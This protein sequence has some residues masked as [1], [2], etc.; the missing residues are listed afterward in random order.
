MTLTFEE[1]APHRATPAIDEPKEISAILGPTNTGKTHY[2]IERMLAHRSGVI[3]LPLRLLAREVYARV[4]ERAGAAAVALIT[5]EERINPGDPRYWV[6]TVE[7]MPRA[8]KADFLAV[9]EIQLAA[10]LERGHTFTDRL[11]NYRGRVETMF[12]GAQTI[13]PVVRSLAPETRI[14]TRPRLS[15]LVHA[16]HRKL[17]RLPHR[18]AVVA[19]SAQD[20]YEIAELLR[21]NY[22]GAAVVLG[23]LSPR[24][25]N[26]QVDLYENRDVDYIVAT[27]A[28][29]MGLNLDIEHVAFASDRKFDGRELRRLTFAE[30]GQIAGRAGR[31][32][33]NGS[34]GA[35]GRCTPFEPEL[36][37]ALENHSFEPVLR[38]QWRNSDLDFSSID[39]LLASLRRF[40]EQTGLT[41]CDSGDDI[42]AL[43][44]LGFDPGVR[45]AAKT[46]ADVGRLWDAC[47]IPDYRNVS[48]GAHAG[49]VKSVFEFIV[50]KGNISEDWFW[51]LLSNADR[52]DGDLDALSSR[53]DQVR[54]CAY[55]ANRSDWLADPGHWQVM[56]R[57]VEDRLSD[58]LH[59][60][61]AQ[62]FIDRRTSMLIR[63]HRENAMLN[64][65]V[66]PAGDLVVEGQKL[67]RVQ[68]FRFT[69]E[70][71]A[72][73][74]A[75]KVANVAIANAVAR[76]AEARA[77]RLSEAVDSSLVLANDGAIRWLGDP[78]AKLVAGDK[79]L[80]PR[81]VIL[82]DEAVTNAAKEVAQRRIDLWLAAHIRR[83]LGPLLDLEAGEGL[84]GGARG[85]AFQLGESLGVLDRGRV[86]QDVK[87]LD[88]NARGALRKLGV[89]FGAYYI[90]VP[91]LLKPAPRVLALQL[92]ALKN[93]AASDGERLSSLPQLTAAGRT[94]FVAEKTASR[95]MLRVAGFRLCGDRAVRVDILERLADL[96]RPAVAY[97]PG[98]SPGAPPAGAADGDGFVVTVA[99]TSLTGCSGEALGSILRAMG[100][101]SRKIKGPAITVPL[102]PAVQAA[103]A[104]EA[105]ASA[106]PST[107]GSEEPVATD[108]VLTAEPTQVAP[109]GSPEDSG[110]AANET[111]ASAEPSSTGSEELV[112]T[113][114]VPTADLTQVA[115]DGPPEDFGAA[116]NETLAPL[117]G[118]GLAAAGSAAP[119]ESAPEIAETSAAPEV[120]ATADA[121]A[122]SADAPPVEGS[123][124]APDA[125]IPSS[126]TASSAAT[127]E[128]EAM[129]EVWRPTHH[130]RRDARPPRR[131]STAPSAEAGHGAPAHE[132][133]GRRRSKSFVPRSSEPRPEVA[134]P[135]A[136]RQP[137]QIAAQT[138]EQSRP[139]RPKGPRAEHR[140]SKPRGQDATKG[141]SAPRP[142]PRERPIDPNSPFAKLLALKTELEAKQRGE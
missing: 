118:S 18:S 78:V 12:L 69:P 133:H 142:A 112:A 138:R 65:E 95:D 22:G 1:A 51:G 40:P 28:I 63:R 88:Q 71:E 75:V 125:S 17:T 134:A 4:V 82:A 128:D 56:A 44:M 140:P 85:I 136:D 131:S 29:G 3:G 72:G 74:E 57:Q 76:E 141:G 42:R 90:Y 26:A 137:Q 114:Q 52:A 19:F 124:P 135:G 24:T 47:Q 61:L 58:A 21:R 126:P 37:E 93:E 119:A 41:R 97:R 54:S 101:E 5:G 16:G 49:L 73:A 8:I 104:S 86:A 53:I 102:V 68:G 129:V 98:V 80:Q 38:A 66:T 23:A 106:E 127:P 123:A 92:W 120:P 20:V 81:A 27:D 91:S 130:R 35:T 122:S 13:E 10:D 11:L 121:Q 83:V 62:R 70:P 59:E 110:G 115:P 33:R 25:R 79:Q 7:A 94:S 6:C 132:R 34:F 31:N 64:A 108:Q 2:A 15:S 107:T 14:T 55:M 109:D 77:A 84:E 32:R 100:F 89:R 39:A 45:R 111:L 36:V 105:L 116:V 117:A 113:D 96:I 50:R 48:G 99:M 87:S 139:E 60:R 46:V 67:G 43:E 30:F 103:A 9:D